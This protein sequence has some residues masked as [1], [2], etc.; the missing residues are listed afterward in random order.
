MGTL[1][2][3][4]TINYFS[5]RCK[6]LWDKW[7][8]GATNKR[9]KKRKDLIKSNLDQLVNRIGIKSLKIEFVND[10]NICGAFGWGG[11][12]MDIGATSL[13][14]HDIKCKAFVELC[15]T[16]YHET[17]HA[18]QFTRIAQGIRLKRLEHNGVKKIPLFGR[19]LVISKAMGMNYSATKYA[20][21]H[22]ND[23]LVFVATPRKAHCSHSSYQGWSNWDSTVDD[24][25]QRTYSRSKSTFSAIGQ[26]DDVTNLPNIG[27]QYSGGGGTMDVVGG[28]RG[29][30]EK[31]YY[32][33]AEDEKDAYAI[34]K[35]FKTSLCNRFVN[36][37]SKRNWK[38][39]D[40][41]WGG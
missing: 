32:Y 7:N 34:E 41:R 14:K 20:L 31:Q 12:Q 6:D 8:L 15:V 17:R 36:Y 30:I 22:R 2:E 18:E 23:Y 29:A 16:L 40:S 4:R 37:T 26:S 35:L 5:A 38:R 21:D 25:M 39:D 27:G 13:A 19:S 3:A 11:W 24:W 33:R 10:P 1:H 28:R 9:L